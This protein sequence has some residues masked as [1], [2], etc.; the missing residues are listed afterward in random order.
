V[1]I[2]KASL[3]RR[4]SQVG[5]FFWSAPMLLPVFFCP[6]RLPWILCDECTYYWCPA[7]YLRKPLAVVIIGSVIISG[8]SFCGWIC[9]F[10][11]IQDV[12]NKIS[13]VFSGRNLIVRINPWVRYALLALLLVITL[14]MLDIFDFGTL[15][16]FPYVPEY[17]PFVLVIAVLASA[18]TLRFWCRFLCPLGSLISFMNK[19]S[20]I[21]L[22][23]NEN[24]CGLDGKRANPES[25][26]CIRCGECLTRC[27]ENA[28][29]GRI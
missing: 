12:M 14:Y 1:K 20:L 6:Y 4:I 8:R 19:V 27:P 29:G 28:R 3:L 21:K 25:V 18:F 5:F 13:R 17:L 2:K 15:S 16:L 22:N 23:I 24:R 26:D 11:T 9:P 10:G 7:K